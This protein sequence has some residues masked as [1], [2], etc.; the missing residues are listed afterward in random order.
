MLVTHSLY[1]YIGWTIGE[2]VGRQGLLRSVIT[3][4]IHAAVS[5]YQHLASTAYMAQNQTKEQLECPLT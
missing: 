4:S 1:E 5:G 3:A 2:L